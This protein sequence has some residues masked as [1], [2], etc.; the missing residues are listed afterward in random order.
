MWRLIK[1]E[2]VYNRA[3]LLF[4][5]FFTSIPF[6]LYFVFWKYKYEEISLIFMMICLVIPGGIAAGILA[7]MG[8]R[9]YK[10]RRERLYVLVPL[11]LKQIGMARALLPF[12]LWITI[13]FLFWIIVMIFRPYYLELKMVWMTLSLT[14]L[15]LGLI[16]T[17]YMQHD[18]QFYFFEKYQ[19]YIWGSLLLFKVLASLLVLSLISEV[20]RF[21]YPL[22]PLA[23]HIF[24]TPWGAFGLILFALIVTY[25]SVIAFAKRKSYVE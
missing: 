1:A 25:L 12:L 17:K 23:E 21:L 7:G 13:V 10:E 19:K 20:L 6:F 3:L 16:S 4:G 18:V 8:S 9:R 2:F 14:G 22:R 15:F 5:C 24:F 11:S